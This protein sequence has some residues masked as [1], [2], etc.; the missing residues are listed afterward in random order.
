MN[1]EEQIDTSQWLEKNEPPV[2]QFRA[3]HGDL[4]LTIDARGE[5]SAAQ[6]HVRNLLNYLHDSGVIDSQARYNG[7]TYELWQTCFRAQQGYRTNPIYGITQIRGS[8]RDAGFADG[9]FARLIFRLQAKA[10]NLIEAAISTTATE[11]NKF[12]AH[13]NAAKYQ[14]AFQ[15][16]GIIMEQLRDEAT[17][18][19]EEFNACATR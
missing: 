15:R 19:A 13:K 1:N 16:L 5:I 7:Q 12:L 18:R 11:H 2:N 10:A 8:V 14:A 6:A 9:D 17:A 3:Q 4:T